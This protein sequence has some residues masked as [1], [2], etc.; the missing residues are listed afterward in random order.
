MKII[1]TQSNESINNSLTSFV[2]VLESIEILKKF[3]EYLSLQCINNFD[4]NSISTIA[5]EEINNNNQNIIYDLLEYECLPILTKMQSLLD[6]R[7]SI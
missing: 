2:E 6:Q 4:T 1:D 5:M 7:V 3:D